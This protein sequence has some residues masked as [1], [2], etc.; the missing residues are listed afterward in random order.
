MMLS[1]AHE[2]VISKDVISLK[3]YNLFNKYIRVDWFEFER[4]YFFPEL[5]LMI[6]TSSPTILWLGQ[7]QEQRALV[8]SGSPEAGLL[9][10]FP[11]KLTQQLIFHLATL[12]QE[13]DHY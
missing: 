3:A 7:G 6:N 1:K 2:V 10:C 13:P 9:G 4:T 8:A 12:L 11:C 5:L